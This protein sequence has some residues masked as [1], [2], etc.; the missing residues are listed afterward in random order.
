M[1]AQVNPVF[2]YGQLLWMLKLDMAIMLFDLGLNRMASMSDVNLLT[3]AGDTIYAWYFSRIILDE[4][5]E[6]IF[7]GR[8]ATV[9]I[10]L[11]DILLM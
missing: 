7:L 6:T 11:D 8:M 4:S 10:Y 9:L 2:S 5:V 1:L 3:L